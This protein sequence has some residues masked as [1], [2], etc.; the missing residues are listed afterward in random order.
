MVYFFVI[1]EHQPVEM[2]GSRISLWNNVEMVEAFSQF[3]FSDFGCVEVN[4]LELICVFDKQHSTKPRIVRKIFFGQSV[5]SKPPVEDCSLTLEFPVRPGKSNSV[6]AVYQ[7]SFVIAVEYPLIAAPV[8][9]GNITIRIFGDV[10]VLQTKAVYES[11]I[12]FSESTISV[13]IYYELSQDIVID[14]RAVQ[15]QLSVSADF[16]LSFFRFERDIFK[17]CEDKNLK[18]S[19]Y[20]AMNLSARIGEVL[21][22]Q[23]NDIKN[24]NEEAVNEGETYVHV[25]KQISRVNKDALEKIKNQDNKRTY[26]IFP[27]EK[28]DAKS[29]L[30]LI[31]L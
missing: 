26:K 9:H 20:L 18:M 28:E 11:Q 12:V 27:N 16:I 5:T 22:L 30:A 4:I 25:S 31:D 19:M 17:D 23:W 29:F 21:G 2:I 15:N 14:L 13:V 1:R 8:E 3:F 6:D 24:L 7:D 10:S